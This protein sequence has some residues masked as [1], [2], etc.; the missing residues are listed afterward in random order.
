[1]RMVRLRQA[2]AALRHDRRG[3]SVIE[4]AL[5]L[6]LLLMVLAGMV[7]VSRFVVAR[8]DVELAAQRTTDFVLAKRPQSSDTSYIVTEAMAAADVEAGQ[9]T[10]ELFLECDGVRKDQFDSYCAAGEESARYVQ[11]SIEKTVEMQFDWSKLASLFGSQVLGSTITLE[12]TS[13]ER[14]Q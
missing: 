3:A 5:V 2:L 4:L 10:A 7:E 13:L 14:I 11:V 6:P 8:I 12:G 9:V 1:M